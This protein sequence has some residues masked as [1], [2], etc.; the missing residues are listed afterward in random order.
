MLWAHSYVC[1]K[2]NLRLEVREEGFYSLWIWYSMLNIKLATEVSTTVLG[3]FAEV[4][5][6]IQLQWIHKPIL[7]VTRNLSSTRCMHVQPT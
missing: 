6:E 3:G 2:T 4:F 1:G 7:S 5:G